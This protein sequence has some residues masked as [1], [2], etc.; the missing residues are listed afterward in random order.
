[1]TENQTSFPTPI[2]LLLVED[3]ED[4]Y[5]IAKDLLEQIAPSQF[6]LDWACNAEVARTA[7]ARDEHHV[8]LMDYRL[9]PDDGLKLLREAPKLG[10]HGPIIMLTGQD[11]S[12]LDADALR[13]GAVD[14][15]VKSDLNSAHLARAIRYA[16]A[17]REME[18]ERLVRLKAE[19][20]NRSKSEFLAHLSHELRTPLT[21]ILGYTELLIAQNSIPDNLSHLQIVQRN[22]QHLLSLLNDI[23]D[24][25]KIEAGKLEMEFVRVN[26]QTYLADLYSLMAVSARDKNLQLRFIADMPLPE[27]IETDPIRL[28]QVLLNLIGN[29]IKFTEQGEII[30]RVQMIKEEEQEKIQFKVIDTGP[31]INQTDQKR[32]F[33]PFTQAYANSIRRSEGAGLGLAISRQLAQRLGGDIRLSSQPGKGSEFTAIVK[34]GPLG[35]VK[36][37][38]PDLETGGAEQAHATR[39]H[40]VQGHILVADDLQDI[41]HLIGHLVE[42][43]GAQVSYAENGAEAVRMVTDAAQSDTPIDLVIMDMHMPVLDGHSAT[44]ELR[45]RGHEIPV[46]A[47]TAA[48]MRGERERCLASGCTDHLSKPVNINQLFTLIERHLSHPQVKTPTLLLVEDNPDASAAT[49]ALLEHLGWRVF[50]AGNGAEAL[51][52]AERVKPAAIVLD[53]NLPDTDGY[54]LAQ[55]IREKGLPDA[56]LIALSGCAEDKGRSAEAGFRRHLMKPVSMGELTAVLPAKNSL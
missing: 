3:D 54:T 12:R 1:M 34:P 2:K 26:L 52:L 45:R 17:R 18:T 5:I 8:C 47:L 42:N 23:L 46:L 4:D 40:R 50:C 21:A 7:L 51:E 38:Q 28:R 20:E 9:G 41:R 22:G 10:F 37:I 31:G 27:N 53:L 25:S 6:E 48:T 56:H 44:R 43:A 35:G 19:A 14:Y 33:Q 13:G 11:D 49:A 30:V 15:L 36:R 16:L 55:E 24:I 29:A 32:L 39:K